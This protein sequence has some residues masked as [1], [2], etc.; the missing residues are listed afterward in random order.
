MAVKPKRSY[1]R[2]GPAWEPD[3]RRPGGEVRG[4]SIKLPFLRITVHRMLGL[5]G[6]WFVSCHDINI[7]GV[8]IATDRPGASYKPEELQNMAL[9]L[10]AETLK[11][12]QEA[13]CAHRRSVL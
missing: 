4:W 1:H 7:D 13:L 3:T 10:V 2:A 9:Q 8:R 11:N 5:E 12:M 6:D